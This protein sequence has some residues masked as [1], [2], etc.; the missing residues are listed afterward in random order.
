MSDTDKPYW[1]FFGIFHIVKKA[2]LVSVVALFISLTLLGI[3]INQWL[4][5]ASLKML[6]P[7]NVAIFEF[8]CNLGPKNVQL[9]VP[10]S[11]TNTGATG[12]TGV[13]TDVNAV[14]SIAN[15]NIEFGGFQRVSMH[16][17]PIKDAK[18]RP[19]SPREFERDGFRF[20]AISRGVVMN[21]T[22]SSA[23]VTDIH[24][25][26]KLK[27]NPD[28]TLA[29]EQ[30]NNVSLNQFSELMDEAE[31]FKITIISKGTNDYEERV[32]CTYRFSESYGE[33][34]IMKKQGWILPRFATCESQ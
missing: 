25:I 34:D 24:F 13:V 15:Q 32:R 11:Y 14:L 1:S 8:D 2:D 10:L 3:Q 12:Y 26:P 18:E 5:G 27:H 19:C 28:G 17:Q 21:I 16:T 30:P 31:T 20:E 33:A 9:I 6:E 4:T 23:I 22:A 7:T 29:E